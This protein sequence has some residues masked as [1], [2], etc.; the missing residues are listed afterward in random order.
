MTTNGRKDRQTD[1]RKLFAILRTRL[2]TLQ[3]INI[4]KFPLGNAKQRE[5]DDI[6]YGGEVLQ[7]CLARSTVCPFGAMQCS[8]YPVAHCFEK[9]KERCT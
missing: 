9:Y 6:N 1:M 5:Y 7:F 2:K 4:P 3:F 8:T